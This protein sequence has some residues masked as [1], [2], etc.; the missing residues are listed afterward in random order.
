VP[1]GS[2]HQVKTEF[3]LSL[4]GFVLGFDFVVNDNVRLNTTWNQFETPIYQYTTIDSDGYGKDNNP[5]TDSPGCSR[6]KKNCLALFFY[7]ELNA[8]ELRPPRMDD[9]GRTKYPVL[10]R[11]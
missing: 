4:N 2:A 8:F 5:S 10:F 11:V 6:T 7:A 1:G 3:F 9:S